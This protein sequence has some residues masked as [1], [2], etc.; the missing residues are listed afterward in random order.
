M[1]K[2]D[3]LLGSA[4]IW[5]RFDTEVVDELT[6]GTLK[7]LEGVRLATIAEQGDHQVSPPPLVVRVLVDG[8]LELGQVFSAQP[9]VD[10]ERS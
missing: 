9:D 7:H 1:L 6:P 3:F 5:T 2:E 4:Q 10:L 8:T